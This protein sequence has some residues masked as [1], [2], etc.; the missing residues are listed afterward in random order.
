MVIKTTITMGQ[1][2]K[3][4]K[5]NTFPPK[6]K[7]NQLPN[8]E[9]KL[10]FWE[11]HDLPYWDE[12]SKPT[13]KIIAT[14]EPGGLAGD[15]APQICSPLLE[16][17]V[18]KKKFTSPKFQIDRY[19][20][21]FNLQDDQYKI[22][23]E[24]AKRLAPRLVNHAWVK[25]MIR[26]RG[27]YEL[28]DKDWIISDNG[29]EGSKKF[30]EEYEAQE[31]LVNPLLHP[32]ELHGQVVSRTMDLESDIKH[33]I[34]GFINKSKGQY[35]KGGVASLV[36]DRPTNFDNGH[37][38]VRPEHLEVHN[39]LSIEKIAKVEVLAKKKILFTR[40]MF[41]EWLIE[42]PE[43]LERISK[44]TKKAHAAYKKFVEEY[45]GAEGLVS[46]TIECDINCVPYINVETVYYNKDLVK[47]E[48]GNGYI[49]KDHIEKVLLKKFKTKEGNMS[50]YRGVP[51]F[52]GCTSESA[53]KMHNEVNSWKL[54]EA[55][56]EAE[57]EDNG[58][59]E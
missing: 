20:W 51:I 1:N 56:V 7:K 28:T 17:D 59:E 54:I 25:K 21:M 27:I 31:K 10:Q 4:K 39:S 35:T 53:L 32:N 50:M 23:L 38:S 40:R 24:R 22:S 52:I 16:W 5:T 18:L 11:M 2:I 29:Y 46:I 36:K 44:L 8:L 14:L 3:N 12:K 45:G 43:E 34:Y 13:H 19:V 6:L 42:H 48:R 30:T 47:D 33:Q 57:N 37:Q 26:E 15:K 41:T 55:E 58:D 9:G 49:R